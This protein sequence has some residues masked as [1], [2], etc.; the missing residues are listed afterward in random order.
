MAQ[1]HEVPAPPKFT[2]D[3]W[4]RCRE[5]GDY[6]PMLF[7][8]YKFVGGLCNFFACIRP[9]SPAVRTI[10]SLHYAV[11]IGLLNRCSRLMLANVALSH[12]GLFGETTALIDRCI[13]ESC[14][15][16][17]WLCQ[18]DS[19]DRF[20]RFLA[21]GLRTEIELKGTIKR[22]IE[23]RGGNVLTIEKRMLSS[24]D[25]HMASAQLSEDQISDTKRLPDLAA[26]IK[27]LDQD[28]LMYIV[29]QRLGSHHIHGT[30]PSL[31]MHYLEDG[32]GG[33]LR[34]RDHNCETHVNQYVFVPMVVLTA[35][36]SF[37]HF[38]FDD[39]DDVAP[40][41]GLLES[42]RQEIAKVNKEVVG[43]DFERAEEI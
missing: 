30:W 21:D 2:E 12:E 28:R 33:M 26:M 31:R 9:D 19:G 32:E 24:I 17:A 39:E 29:G 5:S 25:R 11:V 36:N 35:M 22:N 1:Q 27:G 8:W 16:I 10:P 20:T 6:C 14:V 40:M 18:V 7:E 4:K 13:F 41:A 42:I 23:A 38:L 43:N 15:K 34:P 37:V 3:D